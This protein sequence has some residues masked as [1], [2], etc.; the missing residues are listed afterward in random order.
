[1]DSRLIIIIV[2]L[3][4]GLSKGGVG[5]PI[6]VGLALPLLTQTMDAKLAV[7]LVLP[8]LIV[9]DM[10]A[11]RFYWKQWDEAAIRLLL[12]MAVVG[13]VLGIVALN[14]ITGD[15]L[16]R[17]IGVFSLVVIAYRLLSNRLTQVAYTHRPWHGQF[18]GWMGGFASTLANVGGPPITA[19][20]LLQEVSPRVFIGTVTLFFTIVNLLKVPGYLL[21]GRDVFDINAF[22]SIAWVIPLIPVGVWLGRKII[23]WLNPKVFEW[24]MLAFLLYSGLSLLFG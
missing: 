8:L 16:K 13:V 1:M 5:G 19:Y 21:L 15:A 3:L 24:V 6:S 14:F 4:I 11:M 2:G 10:F 12:P 22:L 20:L 17:V 7:G 23:G 18:A 9:A